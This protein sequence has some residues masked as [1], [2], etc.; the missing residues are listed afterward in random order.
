MT[1]PARSTST[2]RLPF[3]VV[4]HAEIGVDQSHVPGGSY[5]GRTHSLWFCDA[6]E[7]GQ[8]A[9]FE[10]AFMVH[11]MMRGRHTGFSA[12]RSY[13]PFSAAPND[14]IAV[15][16]LGPGTGTYQSAWPFTALV[17]D[18]LD[19]FIDRWATLLAQASTGQLQYPS[20]MPERP[21]H[22]TWRRT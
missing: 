16:A 7:S 15:Q 14:E 6:R 8:Y 17:D 21:P 4:A 10:T 5:C 13:E 18:D 19:E 20:S 12:V 9:W 2:G 22:D 11:P 3:D 1:S